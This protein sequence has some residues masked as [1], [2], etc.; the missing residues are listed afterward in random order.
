M[1][2]TVIDTLLGLLLSFLIIFIIALFSG[3]YHL[4]QRRMQLFIFIGFLAG[5]T[6]SV[7]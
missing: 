7:K 3:S 4:L 2:V 6:Q 5:I 1:V